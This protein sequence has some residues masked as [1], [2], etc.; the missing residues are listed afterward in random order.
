MRWLDRIIDSVSMNL[1]KLWEIMED[2]GAWHA[3]VHGV[4]KSQTGLRN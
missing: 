3:T 4:A 1:S 2:R